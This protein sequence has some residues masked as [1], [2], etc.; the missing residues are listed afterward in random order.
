LEKFPLE[1]IVIIYSS[2]FPLLLV[3]Y[4]IFAPIFMV[5]CW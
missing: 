1:R 3:M 5:I 2:A 4:F